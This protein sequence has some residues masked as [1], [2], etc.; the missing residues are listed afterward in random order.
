[1]KHWAHLLLLIGMSAAA[2]GTS[3]RIEG[4]IIA[5]R[6]V[7]LSPPAVQ[8]VFQFNIAEI[9]PEG[10]TVEAGD[11]VV[12]FALGDL[13]RQLLENQNKLAEKTREREQLLLA[14]EDRE[15]KEAL[16]T[17]EA[18]AD[19]EKASRKTS[20]S[21][22]E[23]LRAID[24]RKLVVERERTERRMALQTRRE[25]LARGLRRAE[26]QLVETEISRH[27]SEVDRLTASISGLSVK[28]PIAGMVLYRTNF[29]GAKF[30][31]GSQVWKGVAVA[32]IS[33]TASLA[34]RAELPERELQRISVGDAARVQFDTAAMTDLQAK[35]VR[36]GQVVHSKSRVQPIP[37]VD[38]YLEFARTATGIRPGQPVSVEL[39][40]RD[41][42]TIPVLAK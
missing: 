22:R 26:L 16:A 14:L 12:R 37:V 1:M 35:L 27:Q 3:F 6:S 42:K 32:E 7:A 40:L 28:T 15:R 8:D 39:N 36:L 41:R 19:L 31:V 33:D 5:G 30:A 2:Q 25:K 17:A 38:L 4:E 11:V 29:E 10:S 23:A 9:A 21:Q 18:Q 13:N 20:Q 24:Y 34:V